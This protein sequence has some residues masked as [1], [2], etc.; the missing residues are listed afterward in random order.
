MNTTLLL[1]SEFVSPIRACTCSILCYRF[2]VAQVPIHQIRQAHIVMSVAQPLNGTHRRT[3][4][5]GI[6]P[7]ARACLCQ[8]RPHRRRFFRL[9]VETTGHGLVDD[10]QV[11]RLLDQIIHAAR[12]R[13]AD[14]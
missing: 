4:D 5:E 6:S 2:A 12:R 11:N 3:G 9:F 8:K 1:I 10:A 14:A 13:G 7:A